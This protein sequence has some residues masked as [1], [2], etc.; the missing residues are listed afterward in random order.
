MRI[1][2]KLHQKFGS[3]SFYILLFVVVI[4]SIS[5]IRNI[6]YVGNAS[7]RILEAQQ[8]LEGLKSE[9]SKLQSELQEIKSRSYLEKQI[10]DK[11]NLVDKGEIVLVLPE[12]EVLK[13]F[14]P[15]SV[16]EAE[17][18]LPPPN[19]KAWFELFI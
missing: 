1:I 11:L 12:E 4:L 8:K 10:R 7:N 19:W 18:F 13:R 17:E 5:L 2:F 15:R 6:I 16:Q 3:F 9:Q 14:S